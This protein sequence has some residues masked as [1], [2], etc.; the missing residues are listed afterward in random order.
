VPR[1]IWFRPF[2]ITTTTIIMGIIITIGG[3][4]IITTIGGIITTTVG[5]I[6]ITTI[7]GIIIITTTVGTITATATRDRRC[8]RT[9]FFDLAVTSGPPDLGGLLLFDRGSAPVGTWL[10]P[11]RESIFFAESSAIG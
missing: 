10:R 7:G 2:G 4:V 5:G 6:I 3:T 8:A 11:A 9:L 1:P